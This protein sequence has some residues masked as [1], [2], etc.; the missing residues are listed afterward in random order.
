MSRSPPSGRDP[1]GDTR[2]ERQNS[3]SS[4]WQSSAKSPSEWGFR[5][6]SLAIRIGNGVSI[7][8]Q[9]RADGWTGGPNSGTRRRRGKTGSTIPTG[10]LSRWRR[11][12][13][14]RGRHAGGARL[15]PGV[16][17]AK[18]NANVLS[19]FSRQST[20]AI[21]CARQSKS[22]APV[23]HQPESTRRTSRTTARPGR[24]H[25]HSRCASGVGLIRGAASWASPRQGSQTRRPTQTS[26]GSL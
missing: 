18:S 3:S 16:L 17:A 25:G 20:I 9:T 24:T 2:P 14:C 11:F 5:C 4:T 6:R 23:R 13:S 1:P 26:T 8:G 7:V 22:C 12:E 10:L 21:R 19:V 15:A